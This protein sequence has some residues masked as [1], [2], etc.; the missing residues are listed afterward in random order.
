MAKWAQGI[1]KPRNPEKYAGHRNPRY[2]SSWELTFMQFC[3]NNPSI[4]NWASESIKIP[5][6]HPLTG[7]Q[8]VYVPDF[9][10]LYEDRNGRKHAEII[11]IK[12]SSQTFIQEAKSVNNKAALVVNYAK[13]EA[14]KKWAEKNKCYFRIVTEKDIFK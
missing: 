14:A 11:E 8:T 13:W 3:D 10:I 4:L 12:P 6:R 5:Y 9:F 1:F 2:R 7:R